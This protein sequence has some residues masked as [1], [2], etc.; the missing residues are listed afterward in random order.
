MAK[1]YWVVCILLIAAVRVWPHP[2]YV[3]YSG[4]PGSAGRCAGSCHG[5]T[6]GSVVVTGFPA[7]YSPG[8]SY[9]ICISTSATD[10]IANFNATVHLDGSTTDIGTLVPGLNTGLYSVTSEPSG[11]HFTVAMRDTGNFT[12]IAPPVGMDSVMFYLA[13]H[14][15]GLNGPNTLM[16][17]GSAEGPLKDPSPLVIQVL[18]PNIR[19]AWSPVAGA[20]GYYIYR[21]PTATSIPSIYYLYAV[22]SDTSFTQSFMGN[23]GEYQVFYIV[24][25]H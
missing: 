20:T 2:N 22:T 14:E 1:F 25:S 19:L 6:G 10:S 4:A 13:A 17:L 23:P 16:V 11:V 7:R 5:T 24:T 15:G 3:A 21:G 18:P 9:R 12:W 8:Q